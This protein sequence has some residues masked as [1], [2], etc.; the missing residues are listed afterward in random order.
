MRVAPRLASPRAIRA[1]TERALLKPSLRS[2][3]RQFE[4]WYEAHDAGARATELLERLAAA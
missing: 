3:A 1:A 2:T 4:D